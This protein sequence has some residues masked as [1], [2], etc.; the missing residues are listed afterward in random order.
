MTFISFSWEEVI[1]KFVNNLAK[2]ICSIILYLE[3]F[4]Q[5]NILTFNY[6]CNY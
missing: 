5:N 3:K 4:T 6:I 1:N 2:I